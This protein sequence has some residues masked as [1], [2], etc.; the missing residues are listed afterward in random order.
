MKKRQAR[1]NLAGLICSIWPWGGGAQAS[2][3]A[4]SC[5]EI[6]DR[7]GAGC[8]KPIDSISEPLLILSKRP[9][10][11]LIRPALIFVLQRL[12]LDGK[13]KQGADRYGNNRPGFAHKTRSWS[14]GGCAGSDAADPHAP[15]GR[16]RSA[17]KVGDLV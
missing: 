12:Q 10:L 5:Y 6:H 7:S 2:A 8:E 15:A 16:R 1:F 9:N 14:A 13:T 11:L 4:I 17:L 3:K